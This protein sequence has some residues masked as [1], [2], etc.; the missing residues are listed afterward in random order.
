MYNECNKKA[1]SKKVEPTL[2]VAKHQRFFCKLFEFLI[3]CGFRLWLTSGWF[4][5]QHHP[6]LAAGEVLS[7]HLCPGP[8][9][10]GCDQSWLWKRV[11]AITLGPPPVSMLLQIKSSNSSVWGNNLLKNQPIPLSTISPFIESSNMNIAILEIPW[12]FRP[13]MTGQVYEC[14]ISLFVFDLDL[15]PYTVF[16][17]QENKL[18]CCNSLENSV[19]VVKRNLL[20]HLGRDKWIIIPRFY[21]LL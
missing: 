3:V 12:E 17:I 21:Y 15:R 7:P 2:N 4:L 16:I 20:F 11:V 14:L 9:L 10:P 18:S 1:E 13:S 8:L 19:G 6:L 5:G